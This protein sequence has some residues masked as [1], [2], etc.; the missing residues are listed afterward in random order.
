M[1]ALTRPGGPIF[2]D[3]AW[4][5]EGTIA[6]SALHCLSRDRLGSSLERGALS[7]AQ[8]VWPIRK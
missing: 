4:S 7:G 5:D 3:A 6:Q 2:G 8:T 1:A